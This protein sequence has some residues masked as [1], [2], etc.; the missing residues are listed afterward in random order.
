MSDTH[1][2]STPGPHEGEDVTADMMNAS[3]HGSP[4]SPDPSPARETAPGN[5]SRSERRTRRRALISAPVRVR[6]LDLTGN[7][8][9]EI[10][11]TL[12][13]S[14]TGFLFV[15][16]E[17]VFTVGMEVAVTFPYSRTGIGAQAEQPG[18]VARVKKMEDGRFAVAI[19]LGIT[20]TGDLV[21]TGGNRLGKQSAP[22]AEAVAPDSKN[23]LVVAVDADP[24]MREML[25]TYLVSEGYDVIAVSSASEAHEVL[26]MFTPALLI[27]EIEGE[28]L[29]G[30]DLCAHVKSTPRLHTVPVVLTTSSAY[31]SDYAN[32]HSLGAVVCMAKPFRCDR[33]GHVVRL[34]APTPQAMEHTAPVH[35]AD[36]TRKFPSPAPSSRNKGPR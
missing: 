16:E 30:Y 5:A 15:C 3:A 36:P 18:R 31:P 4:A 12:D 7:G 9:C 8:P 13:V 33:L 10:S 24:A 19:S 1:E 6:A 21:D 32:A 28:E 23:P 27:S 25:K 14:R 11:T 35:P 34:L 17:S 2:F 26:K 29:P 22:P 20:A